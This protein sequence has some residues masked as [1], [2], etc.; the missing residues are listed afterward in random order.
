MG[1]PTTKAASI[2]HRVRDGHFAD[3]LEI[4]VRCLR[5][6]RFCVV[7]TTHV[8]HPIVDQ[9]AAT[10][11]HFP[12]LLRGVSLHARAQALDRLRLAEPC[13]DIPCSLCRADCR[14]FRQH[15]CS[16][17]GRHR[18]HR[19]AQRPH[20]LSAKNGNCGIRWRFHLVAASDNSREKEAGLGM[21]LMPRQPSVPSGF[22]G[23][24]A[25]MV[26]G[27]QKGRRGSKYAQDK[28]AGKDQPVERVALYDDCV[29]RQD[30]VPH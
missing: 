7:V 26:R 4:R 19:L 25:Y 28:R 17:C 6:A 14:L 23:T 5:R 1:A 29:R 30:P 8:G 27:H 15:P 24:H 2:T 9:L 3:E 10:S 21:R 13:R 18:R 16:L 12:Q 11:H 20:N 22:P